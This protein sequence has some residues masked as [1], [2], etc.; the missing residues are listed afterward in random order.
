MRYCMRYIV[1]ALRYLKR[2]LQ[3]R[4]AT[5]YRSAESSDAA[6][7]SS[8][9]RVWLVPESHWLYVN[10]LSLRTL[11][12]SRFCARLDLAAVKHV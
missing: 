2:E 11:G 1:H 9:E 12:L 3:H 5:D 7:R 8:A 4:S 10:P 6:F